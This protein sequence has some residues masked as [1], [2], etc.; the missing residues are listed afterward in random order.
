VT[1]T[2][3][4]GRRVVLV[5]AQKGAHRIYIE[6]QCLCYTPPFTAFTNVRE[7]L[8]P[9]QWSLVGSGLASECSEEEAREVVERDEDDCFKNYNWRSW[10]SDS[11]CDTAID[12]LHSF[13]I[14][15]GHQKETCIV[16][17]NKI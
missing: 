5:D 16:L 11:T 7:D 8:P 6:D 14:A 2:T 12:S 1:R 13:V 4:N 9:G 3:L 17:I 15:N 10:H